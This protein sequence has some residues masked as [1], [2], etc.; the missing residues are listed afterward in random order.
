MTVGWP[1]WLFVLLA[2]LV[3]PAWAAEPRALVVHEDSAVSRQAAEQLGRELI[4]LGWVVG[5]AAVSGERPLT[6]RRE[7]EHGRLILVALGSR[8]LGAALQKA[9]G[10][11]VVG[12]LIGRSGLDEIKPPTGQRWSVVLLDQPPERWANLIQLAFP[13][14]QQVG[15]LVGP[16]GLRQVQILEQNWKARGLGVALETAAAS[17]DVIPALERLLPRINLLL[18]L[19]DPVTH[20]RNTVQPLLLTTYRAGI[21]V[22]AYSE[23]Y[24]QA[25]AVLALYSTVP[26]VLAQVTEVLRQIE[27]GKTPANIQSPRYFTIGVNTAVARSLGLNLPTA[28]D[29]QDRL[30]ALDQ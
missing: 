14:R 9:A 6:I 20:N 26:Q 11:P 18:A 1:Y 15:L 2:S 19:P 25:G 8:S 24:Q 4:R 23:A 30:R 12:A 21:P 16:G 29:L 3:P 7:D 22:L 17:D 10:R 13:I 5:V 28:N 27:D